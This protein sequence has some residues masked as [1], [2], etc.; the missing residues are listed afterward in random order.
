M[1]HAVG[2]DIGGTKVAIAVVGETGE[3]LENSVI[4][5]D[6]SSRPEDMIQ[7]MIEAIQKRIKETSVAEEDCGG[8][9]VGVPGLLDCKSGVLTNPGNLHGWRVVP[10]VEIVKEALSYSVTLENDAN[11]A[12]VGEKWL[13][14]GKENDNFVY[15]TVSTG[16]GA[17]IIAEGKLL[18]GVKGNAGDFGHTVVDPSFGQCAG[19]QSGCLEVAASGTA[20]AKQGSEIMGKDL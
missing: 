11:A 13:G 18:R 2:V 17:G 5:T 3:V 16:V 6:L 9:G 7:R 15:M 12:A 1:R 10:I 4:P 8:S 19:G 14:A 20:I